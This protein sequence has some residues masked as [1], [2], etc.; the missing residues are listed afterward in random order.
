[1]TDK[2]EPADKKE[3]IFFCPNVSKVGIQLD[4]FEDIPATLSKIKKK[5]INVQ[6]ITQKEL[7]QLLHLMGAI[8]QDKNPS[9]QNKENE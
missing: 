8:E 9:V 1:M 5:G 3:K 7:S 6:G 4:I 2:A